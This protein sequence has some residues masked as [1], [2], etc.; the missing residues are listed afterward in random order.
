MNSIIGPLVNGE[1]NKTKQK[2][3]NQFVVV[4]LF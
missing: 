2:L 1:N 4:I 3:Q